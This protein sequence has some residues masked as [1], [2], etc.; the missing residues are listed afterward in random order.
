MILDND[1]I[2]KLLSDPHLE[3]RIYGVIGEEVAVEVEL[4]G[5]CA[6]DEEG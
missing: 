3:A 4:A 2:I 5:K 6:V 1:V